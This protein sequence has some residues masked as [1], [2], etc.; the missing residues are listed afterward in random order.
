M[1]GKKMKDWLKLCMG[2][3]DRVCGEG[4][5]E[6]GG[7]RKELGWKGDGDKVEGGKNKMDGGLELM[8]KMGME[9]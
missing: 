9:Y 4:G 1:M 3:W 2:W 7:G 6:L 5:E 8:E